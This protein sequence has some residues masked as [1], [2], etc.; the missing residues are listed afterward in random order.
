[1]KVIILSAGRGERLRPLTDKTPK[2]LIRVAKFRLIEYLLYA[3]SQAGF[4]DIIINYA[5]LGD[6]FPRLLGHGQ[7][8]GVKIHY[9]PEQAGGLETAGGIINALP[10]LGH[11]P[12]LVI[13]GDLWT[14]YPLHSL[15]SFSLSNDT[16]CHLVL[17]NNPAHN[18]AGDF[19]LISGKLSQQ[20]IKKYTYSGIGIYHP[21]LFAGYPTER[22]A[23]KPL[24]LNA[25][26][27]QRAS[28]ELYL[29]DWSDIGTLE[30]LEELKMK[31]I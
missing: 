16:L 9:S 10:M 30:R 8:Y 7:K 13:N 21:D 27:Q 22:L 24:L 2:P 23:L 1:M 14:D 29:G 6:Q 4:N 15:K 25:I 11:Q 20:G 19:S 5:H 28:G 31:L 18:A 26:Q 12:F 3:L 17:V